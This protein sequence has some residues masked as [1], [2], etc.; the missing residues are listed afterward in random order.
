MILRGNSC[1]NIWIVYKILN[2]FPITKSQ[3]LDLVVTEIVRV[4][5][6]QGVYA[7]NYIIAPG[8]ECTTGAAVN[9]GQ[10]ELNRDLQNSQGFA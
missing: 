6:V 9:V 1:G 7:N 3:R 5:S 2:D 4:E 10:I 8:M